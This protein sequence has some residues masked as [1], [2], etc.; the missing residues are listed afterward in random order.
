MTTEEALSS[1]L[2]VSRLLF[3]TWIDDAVGSLWEA[4][5]REQGWGLDSE[6]GAGRVAASAVRCTPSTRLHGPP[7]AFSGYSNGLAS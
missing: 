2:I 5:V 3:I 4:A 6:P 7:G 1:F